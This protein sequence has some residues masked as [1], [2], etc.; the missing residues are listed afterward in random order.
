VSIIS[1]KIGKDKR[2]ALV[3]K[4]SKESGL[5]HIYRLV[6]IARD[7]WREEIRTLFNVGLER[8]SVIIVDLPDSSEATD[9]VNSVMKKGS[10]TVLF[11]N[12]GSLGNLEVDLLV[13]PDFIPVNPLETKA[14]QVLTGWDY[15][16]PPREIRSLKGVP[17]EGKDILVTFGGSDPKGLTKRFLS[18]FVEEAYR[19]RGNVHILFGPLNSDYF[20]FSSKRLPPNIRLY[21]SLRDPFS[22]YR[23]SSF[24]ISSGGLSF[25]Y[26]V[27]LGRFTIGIPQNDMEERRIR[28]YSNK[29]D[30]VRFSPSVEDAVK[31]VLC[32]LESGQI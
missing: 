16:Y 17:P 29:C 8:A 20:L 32:F 21:R 9:V 27:Y 30:F 5:G 10:F 26:S 6:Y 23:Y 24:V 11:D 15:V 12:D 2:V 7:L 25:A 13:Y 22:L 19:V 3:C 1:Q 18:L 4:G 14:K 28:F 31:E